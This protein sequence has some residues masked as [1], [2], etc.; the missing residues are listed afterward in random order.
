M[1]GAFVEAPGA[2]DRP[3]RMTFFRNAGATKKLE[4][5]TTLRAFAARVAT[6]SAPEKK[7]LPWVKLAAFGSVCIGC[8]S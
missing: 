6:I 1:S 8:G 5:E 2:L 3:I 7:P 4:A